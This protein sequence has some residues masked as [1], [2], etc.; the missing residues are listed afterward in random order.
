[1][2][3]LL[4]P[5][6]FAAPL[7]PEG[8][9]ATYRRLRRQVFTG[10]YV[11]Y[12][13]YYLVRNNLAL[14]I[15]DILREHPEYS[16]AALGTGTAAGFTGLFGYAFGAALSGSGIGWVADRFG[17]GAVFAI[18]VGCCLLTILFSALTLGHRTE[19]VA[20]AAA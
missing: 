9:E 14:A 8:V 15:P 11:G 4:K 2:I 19:S 7:P 10:I 17:W 12:A 5:A 16:K 3:G 20:Y 1:M 13:A 18:M 6:E